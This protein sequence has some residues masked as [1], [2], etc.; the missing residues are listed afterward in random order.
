MSDFASAFFAA[1]S[2]GHGGKRIGAGRK[3]KSEEQEAESSYK[4]Y[5]DAKARNE[6]AKA[7]LNELEVLKQTKAYLP[8]D[9]YIEASATA[10]ATFAQ[11]CRTI[12]DALERK[13]V[14]REVCQ[15]VEQTLDAALADLAVELEKFTKIEASVEGEE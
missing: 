15:K 6:K 12:P 3:K 14:P 7:D 2:T 4:A 9:A 10:I 11:T 5:H 8:R 1:P 13:G